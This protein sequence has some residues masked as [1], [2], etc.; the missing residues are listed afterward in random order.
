MKIKITADSTCDLSKELA[1]RYGVDIIPLYV[2]MDNKP[3]RD[4]I[5]I[6][7][8]DVFQYYERTGN[9]CFTSACNIG[10]YL[11]T[12]TRLREEYDAVIHISI[13]SEFSSTHQNAVLAA[14]ELE[15]VYVFDSRNLSSGHG[16]L[17]IRA[18]ELTA[19]GMTAE[20]ILDELKAMVD[21]V[22]TSFIVDQL[23][24]L[25][26]GG[27]CSSV[28]ALGANLLKLKPCIEVVDGKMQV[29]KK[30]R[31]NYDKCVDQYIRERLSDPDALDTSRVFLT[32]SGVTQGNL[33]TACRAI[34]E[35][36]GEDAEIIIS[37]AG[38]TISCHCGPGTL[39]II[40][41]RK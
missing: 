40:M 8:H 30:Y 22:D 36:I 11:D 1:E 25:H 17:V 13:S 9:L 27:R 3:L 29:G 20:Q 14:Q 2:N 28:A 18:C 24:Y 38:C 33:D 10:E 12:F 23:E 39:G 6:Q 37:T 41:V 32:S 15:N 5:D 35:C 7:P 26:K 4:Q 31:G 16:V 34:R 21:K 19:K